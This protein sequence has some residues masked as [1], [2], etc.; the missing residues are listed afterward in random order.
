MCNSLDGSQRR[1]RTRTKAI[2]DQETSSRPPGIVRSEEFFQSQRSTSSNPSQ[3]PP[4]SRRFST[5][6]RLTSTSTHCGRTSSKSRFCC[7]R[8]LAFGGLLDAQAL[9]LV[10]LAQ[11]GHHALPRAALRAV[12]LHQRP[13]GVSL[14]VLFAVA[15]AN[16]HARILRSLPDDPKGKV[17]TTTPFRRIARPAGNVLQGVASRN[18]ASSRG[19]NMTRFSPESPLLAK[20]G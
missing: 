18:P 19:P 10:K 13:I 7:G 14:A 6:T 9:R 16:E 12:R 2:S 17:F 5:R 8:G 11:I 20:L 3:G 15:R 4:K 1:Q